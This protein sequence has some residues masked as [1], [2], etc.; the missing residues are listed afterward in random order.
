MGEPQFLKESVAISLRDTVKISHKYFVKEDFVT[1]SLFT[2]A[3][4]LASHGIAGVGSGCRAISLK[5]YGGVPMQPTA[6]SSRVVQNAH[7]LWYSLY[8][9]GLFVA[10]QK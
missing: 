2:E 3:L 4:G 1:V 10:I 9:S 7:F 5:L 6:L 8:N